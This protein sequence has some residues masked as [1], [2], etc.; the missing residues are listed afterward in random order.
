M[1]NIQCPLS[2]FQCPLSDVQC[3]MSDVQCPMSNF[4]RMVYIASSGGQWLGLAWENSCTAL[5]A[6][7]R[8]P[9]S[10]FP[11]FYFSGPGPV[12]GPTSLVCFQVRVYISRSGSRFGFRVHV[13]VWVQVRVWI[14]VFLTP[15]KCPTNLFQPFS[16][17]VLYYSHLGPKSGPDQVFFLVWVHIHFPGQVPFTPLGSA[18]HSNIFF[19]RFQALW[20][21][22]APV[23]QMSPGT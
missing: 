11:L 17:P 21:S 6:T 19:L 12:P 2:D 15:R 16:F 9:F 13:H 20:F 5:R 23:H 18:T 4:K 8:K 14:Q 1:S 7:L 3:P 10:T 22:P